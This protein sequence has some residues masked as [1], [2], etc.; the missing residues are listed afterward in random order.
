MQF[1]LALPAIPNALSSKVSVTEQ[2][3][4]GRSKVQTQSKLKGYVSGQDGVWKLPEALVSVS[5]HCGGASVGGAEIKL[6]T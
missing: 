4:E 6:L 1:S 3:V 2:P 5:P